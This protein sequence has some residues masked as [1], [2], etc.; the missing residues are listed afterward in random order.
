[1]IHAARVWHELHL[2]DGYHGG[3]KYTR[4]MNYSLNSKRVIFFSK[5]TRKENENLQERKIFSF[6]HSSDAENYYFLQGFYL[7]RICLNIA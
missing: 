6:D 1:M 2:H 4:C 7:I 5:I 3:A